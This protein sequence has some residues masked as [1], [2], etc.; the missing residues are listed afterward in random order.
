MTTNSSILSW[1][2]PIDRGVWWATVHRV[3]K[4]W[5]QLKQINTHNSNTKNHPPLNLTWNCICIIF[6]LYFWKKWSFFQ[7]W[8]LD[9]KGS[10]APKNWCFWSVVLEKT[11]ESALDYKEI[12][13]VHPKGNQSWIF[14]GRTDAETETPVLWP[15]D[16]KNWLIEKDPDAEKDWRQEE[17]GTKEDGMTG[18]YHWINGH[19]FEQALGVGEGKGS[20]DCCSPW[21]CKESNMTKQ[22]KFKRTDTFILFFQEKCISICL[23]LS[24]SSNKTS[25]FFTKLLWLSLK[26]ILK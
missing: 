8:E 10:W 11:L 24:L 3:S 26:F 13:P 1:R 4:G 16:V 18:C 7:K 6:T 25:G 21:D 9:Y 22:L 5:T 14:M 2:I 17:K 19:K 12:Q 15:P 20:L 23:N